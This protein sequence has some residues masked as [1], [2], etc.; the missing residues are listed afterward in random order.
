MKFNPS[1]AILS[2]ESCFREANNA[3]LNYCYKHHHNPDNEYN[4]IA[5]RFVDKAFIQMLNLLEQLQL[6]S[7]HK[8]VEAMYQKA[9][10]GNLTENKLGHEEPYLVWIENL[11]MHLDIII[12]SYGIHSQH[13][14]KLFKLK[15]MI[16]RTLYPICDPKNYETPPQK[17]ADVHERIESILKCHYPKLKRKPRINKPIKSFEPDSGIPSI[18]TLIEY[19]FVNDISDVKRIADEI[20]AD[21]RGYVSSDWKNFLF[22]IYETRRIRSEDEWNNLLR[23]CELGSNYEALVLHGDTN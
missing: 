2:I 8:I 23:D 4:I 13:R 16:S 10:T 12:E 20:L 17:E 21:T 9:K 22:V 15:K 18:K 14:T 1:T 7:E 6:I 5:C 11:Q 3:F 19:K